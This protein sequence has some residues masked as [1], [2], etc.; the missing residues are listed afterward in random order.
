MVTKV[1]VAMQLNMIIFKLTGLTQMSW[2]MVFV[3]AW[4]WLGM[5]TVALILLGI[6]DVAD[7]RGRR[8]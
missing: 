3:P 7:R 2:L 4:I 1:L 6:A 5:V 8:Y